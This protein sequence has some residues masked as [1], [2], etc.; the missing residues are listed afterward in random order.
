MCVDDHSL[1]AVCI[2]HRPLRLGC[3]VA[4]RLGQLILSSEASLTPGKKFAAANQQNAGQQL[5]LA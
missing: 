4:V 3:K 2:G 5:Q 1:G